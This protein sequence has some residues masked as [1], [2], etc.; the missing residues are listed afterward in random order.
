MFIS[1]TDLAKRK[2]DF[3]DVVNDHI[4]SKDYNPEEDPS[5]WH[6][7]KVMPVGLL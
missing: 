1:D 2:I 7:E 4:S 5:K 3:I 6:S